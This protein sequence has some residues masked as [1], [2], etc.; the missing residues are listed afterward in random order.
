MLNLINRNSAKIILF[1]A[2]SPGSRYLRKEIKE[3][4]GIFNLTLDSALK[5]LLT[6]KVIKEENRLY[7]LNFENALT[8]FLLKEIKNKFLNL[9]LKIQFIILEFVGNI[10]KLK[11]IEKIIL[12]GSYVK[13]PSIYKYQ[14]LSIFYKNHI[15]FT[16]L[17]V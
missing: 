10:D 8:D 15:K 3:K 11:G 17:L 9:P 2:I 7:S 16:N 6:L 14:F 1:L 5:E 4:T 12:F 13:H